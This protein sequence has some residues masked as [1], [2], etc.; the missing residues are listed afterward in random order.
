MTTSPVNDAHPELVAKYTKFLG[1]T[2]R[3]QETLATMFKPSVK[4]ELTP[5]QLERLRA[6]GYIR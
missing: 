4:V 6:L 2:K 5:A 3:D 1:D